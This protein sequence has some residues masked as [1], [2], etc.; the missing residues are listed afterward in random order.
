MRDSNNNAWQ[1][2]EYPSDIGTSIFANFDCVPFKATDVEILAGQVQAPSPENAS[3]SMAS[4][5]RGIALVALMGV[6]IMLE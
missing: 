3:T 5:T 6:L 4:A 2:F 1:M